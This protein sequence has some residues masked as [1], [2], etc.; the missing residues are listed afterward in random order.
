MDIP[1]DILQRMYDLDDHDAFVAFHRQWHD[2]RQAN[3]KYEH[4]YA[5][6]FGNLV[7][8]NRTFGQQKSIATPAEQMEGFNQKIREELD[9][10]L[11]RR[12][13]VV[14]EQEDKSS[15]RIEDKEVQKPEKEQELRLEWE[16][17]FE[18]SPN[19][20]P[21][22]NKVLD[23]DHAK[24]DDLEQGQDKMNGILEKFK[25][26]QLPESERQMKETA[27]DISK[28][29]DTREDRDFE[30]EWGGRYDDREDNEPDKGKDDYELE[31]D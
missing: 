8:G 19:V 25:L 1:E 3:E 27:D 30:I 14:D 26:Q 10:R 23:K 7:L 20:D 9:A 11:G 17:Y 28:E 13:D 29:N 24:E 16:A 5:Q 22:P 12:K 31:M 4:T 21:Q 6:Q 18:Q 2:Y 15:R